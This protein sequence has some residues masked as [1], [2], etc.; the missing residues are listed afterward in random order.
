[1]N[2]QGLAAQLPALQ[3]VLPL[4]AA[5]LAFILRREAVVWAFSTLVAWC[6]LA[7]SW[8]LLAQVMDQGTIAHAGALVKCTACSNTIITCTPVSISG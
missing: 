7:V 2:S 4:M 8:T 3:V 6:T 5:P 1:L